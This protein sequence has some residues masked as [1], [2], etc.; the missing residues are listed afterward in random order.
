MFYISH[1]RAP[2]FSETV[3]HF[4]FSF[5]TSILSPTSTV[6]SIFFNLIFSQFSEAEVFHLCIDAV[7]RGSI[8]FRFFLNFP[9]QTFV[10]LHFSFQSYVDRIFGFL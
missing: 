1:F 7:H 8:F 9:K 5:Q 6:Y 10:I 2:T 3:R 4:T